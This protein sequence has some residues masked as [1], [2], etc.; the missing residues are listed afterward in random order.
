MVFFVAGIRF[1]RAL[2]C[3]F[4]IRLY[5][6]S[7]SVY[8]ENFMSE[9]F[10]QLFSFIGIIIIVRI[11]FGF[12]IKTYNKPIKIELPIWLDVC[13]G[14]L[15]GFIRAVLICL[16]VVFIIELFFRNAPFLQK[17]TI[18]PYLMNMV[19]YIFFL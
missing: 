17:S 3:I 13:L 1:I 18:F 7:V 2:T 8:L 5:V 15:L 10:A 14:V 9:I 12:I 16:T 6:Q 4:L 11:L 19:G